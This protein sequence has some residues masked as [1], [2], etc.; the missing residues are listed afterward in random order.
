VALGAK[1]IPKKVKKSQKKPCIT[2]RNLYDGNWRS[3]QEPAR[4][5]GAKNNGE[6]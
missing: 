3:E 5:V 2:K 1:A 4:E 6:G